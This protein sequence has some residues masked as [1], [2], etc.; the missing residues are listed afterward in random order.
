MKLKIKTIK[1]KEPFWGASYTFK[2]SEN[3]PGI[4]IPV[5]IISQCDI[6]RVKVLTMNEILYIAS[7]DV[8]PLG[9]KYNSKYLVRHKEVYV[10]PMNH[11]SQSVDVALGKQPELF[12]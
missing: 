4:G 10:I 11:F 8:V 12:K 3:T 6:I 7:K 5:P 2:W 9:Q 1:K